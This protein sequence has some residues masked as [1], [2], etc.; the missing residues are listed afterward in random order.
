M[1]WIVGFINS[2]DPLLYFITTLMIVGCCF[3]G[4][5]LTIIRLVLEYR[6]Y[7]LLNKKLNLDDL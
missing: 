3:I 1:M 2:I 7:G 6:N 4:V 5:I